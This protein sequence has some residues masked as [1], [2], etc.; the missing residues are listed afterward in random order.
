MFADV[1]DDGN[2]DPDSVE[3][4]VTSRT[5]AVLPVHLAGRPAPMKEIL[6]IAEARGLAVVE[7]AA[8]SVGASL[9]GRKVG[10]FGR[11][12]CFSLNP[13]K[14][15]YAYGDGGVIT[16]DD[17]ALANKLRQ[18]RSHGLAGRERCEFF[19]YNARLN[20][21]QAALLRVHLRQLDTQTEARRRLAFRYNELL[22][23]FGDVPVEGSGEHCVYQ[24]Y[25]FRTDH[26]DALERHLRENGVEALVHYRTLITEQPAMRAFEAATRL[27]PN[28]R[29][30]ADRI[31]SL[32]LY[33]GL[34]HAQQ[35]RVG[36]LISAFADSHS[37]R[38]QSAQR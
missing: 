5:R 17:E 25:V 20:E 29:R 11:A 10:S 37:L 35:D 23:P 26:R 36:G 19:S 31:L 34:T 16:T 27:T 7:D 3:A 1:R 24:T 15:L 32:P 21:L 6:R 8:Q 4:A 14:N 13:L 30:Y 12:A 28:A 2:L 18:A 38:R 9:D 33:P 22:A